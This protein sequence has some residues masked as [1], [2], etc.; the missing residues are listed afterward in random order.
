MWS[1]YTWGFGLGC[2]AF[3]ASRANPSGT[4]ADDD[5]GQ[6]LGVVG[7]QADGARV[8]ARLGVQPVAEDLRDPLVRA[9]LQQPREEQVPGLQQ[10]EVGLVLHL[11][12][13]Q[14]PGRLEVEQGGGD[15]EELGG[16]V[17]VP[18]RRPWRGCAP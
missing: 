8:A 18:V 9:V 10:G 3:T 1:T 4:D 5:L 17:E 16:L 6:Q 12:G 15:D 2:I 11:G 13:G 14:Q 7:F